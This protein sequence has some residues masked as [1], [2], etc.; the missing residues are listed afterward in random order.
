[1][2]LSFLSFFCTA[3]ATHVMGSD[4]FYRHLGGYEYEISLKFYRD[5]RGVGF[6]NPSSA[7][8]IKCAFGGAAALNLKLKSITDISPACSSN[9]NPCG[10]PNTSLS[11]LGVEEH[12]Y[13]DTIDFSQA[14]FAALASCGTT[15]IIETGQC[16]RNSS[17]NTGPGNNNFYT[18]ASLEF[19]PSSTQNSSAVFTVPPVIYTA[20]NQP[21]TY[22]LG[23]IDSV[24]KDSLSYEFGAPLR[25]WNDSISYS[26]G[27]H[28]GLPFDVYFP[29]STS[30]PYN[31]PN[32]VPPIGIHLD[33]QSGQLTAT[34]SSQQV[35]VLVINV[36]EWRKNS[37]G[38]PQLISVTRRDIELIIVQSPNNNP[39]VIEYKDSVVVGSS[40]CRKF[41][42]SDKVFVPPPPMSPPPTDTLSVVLRNASS[43]LVLN[44]DSTVYASN[45]TTVYGKVCYD[46]SWLAQGN[47]AI[48][49][50]AADDQCP[51]NLETSKTY[52]FPNSGPLASLP[53]SSLPEIDVGVYPSPAI[54]QVNI[55]F[56]HPMKV[57]EVE[58]YSIQGQLVKQLSSRNAVTM[59]IDCS[60][61]SPGSYFITIQTDKGQANKKLLVQ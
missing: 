17:I 5:C 28:Y 50:Y 39:P 32:A 40:T 24:D 20:L 51:L 44:I 35:T 38:V 29:A 9:A 37:S 30:Y 61:W 2:A 11:N 6:A 34:P 53:P 31:D 12:V 54:N 22:T 60:D 59:Q 18:F 48:H 45:K 7:T 58:V 36:K 52:W 14:P 57:L 1:M 16:C 13:V 10:N 56:E 3:S 19:N 43:N 26:S 55:S 25:G 41:E 47:D 33:S 42:V 46:S 49:L 15:L 4:I 21:L 8:R 23:A 27:L